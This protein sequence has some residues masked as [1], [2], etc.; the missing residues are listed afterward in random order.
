MSFTCCPLWKA[1]MMSGLK[2]SSRIRMGLFRPRVIRPSQWPRFLRRD[3]S[4]KLAMLLS[5]PSKTWNV[6]TYLVRVLL[7][8]GK[9]VAEDLYRGTN[10]FFNRP[11]PIWS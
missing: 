9:E 3:R 5:L 8:L 4:E 6:E 11:G 10:I 1:S 2:S 7:Q